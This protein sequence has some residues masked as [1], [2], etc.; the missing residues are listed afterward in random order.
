MRAEP[1][2]NGVAE[3][4]WRTLGEGII[5][6]LTDAGLGPQWWLHAALAFTHIHNRSPNA[7]LKGH[8]PF[9][10]FYG[11]KPDVSLLRVLLK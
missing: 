2:Q 7:A 3:R 8:T 1:H 10:A 4:P 5:A 6:M 11:K 9:E